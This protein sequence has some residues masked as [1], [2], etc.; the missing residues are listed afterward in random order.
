MMEGGT[1]Q[2]ETIKESYCNAYVYILCDRSQHAAGL[3]TMNVELIVN[4][5]VASGNHVWPAIDGETDMADKAFIEDSVNKFTVV[6][7]AFWKT[8]K[9]CAFRLG[10]VH[11][12]FGLDD[13]P[14][15]NIKNSKDRSATT[16]G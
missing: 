3:R 10:K 1:R 11:T 2:H 4:A 13:R 15:T 12:G 5:R 16:H 6:N 8:L 7:T 9:G 14:L